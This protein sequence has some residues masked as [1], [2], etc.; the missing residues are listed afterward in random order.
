MRSDIIEYLEVEIKRRCES[1]NNF[2]GMGCF[3]HIH[4]VVQ[5]AI[6]LAEQ[7]HA[8]MLSLIHI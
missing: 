8:D 1:E 2:F 7:Y 4:A 3:Y 6:I 5:N